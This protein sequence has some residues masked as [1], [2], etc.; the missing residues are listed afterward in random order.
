MLNVMYWEGN[1]KRIERRNYWYSLRTIHVSKTETL[2]Y[3][4]SLDA[5]LLYLSKKSNES[6]YSMVK[7]KQ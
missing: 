6:E 3:H 4:E 7:S 2:G 5:K 1:F